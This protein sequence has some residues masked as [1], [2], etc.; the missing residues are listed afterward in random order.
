MENFRKLALYAMLGFGGVGGLIIARQSFSEHPGLIG[1]VFTSA[2]LFPMVIGC[3][4]AWRRPMIAFPLLLIW[5]LSI[6]GLLVWQALSP[7]W[8]ITV[9]DS[10][11]P[12]ITAAIFALAPPLAIYG[13]ERRTRFIGLLLIGLSLLNMLATS[14]TDSSGNTKLL[15]TIPVLAAGVLYVVASFSEKREDKPTKA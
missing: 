1:F 2:W 13:Y 14:N 8:W 3:W 4:L 7:S 15:I 11:G 12:I 9:I 5:A 6:L 10:N